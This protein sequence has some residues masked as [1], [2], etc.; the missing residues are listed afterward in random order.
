MTSKE[1]FSC[2]TGHTIDLNFNIL[3]LKL[4]KF[5]CNL[6]INNVVHVKNWNRMQNAQIW[7]GVFYQCEEYEFM[8]HIII[9]RAHSM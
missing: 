9:L 4:I 8:L 2:D 5:T 1:T 3:T 7:E 6:S